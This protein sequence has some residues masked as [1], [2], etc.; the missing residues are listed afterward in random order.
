M[1]IV[2]FVLS[3]VPYGGPPTEDCVPHFGMTRDRLLTR[4][5]E[6]VHIGERRHLA[7][8]ELATLERATALV[9]VRTV[10]DSDMAAG[11]RVLRHGIWHWG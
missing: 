8:A 5:R 2:E 3:W 10:S 7:A 1:E 4:F 6:I 9:G 11:R